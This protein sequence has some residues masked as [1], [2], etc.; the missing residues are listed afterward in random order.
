MAY[1]I[2]VAPED[3]TGCG[4][5]VEICPVK[6]K[7]QEELKALNMALW[8]GCASGSVK[9]TR[10][11]S[12]FPNMTAGWFV[13]RASFETKRFFMGSPFR[14]RGVVIWAAAFV[15]IGS[16]ASALRAEEMLTLAQAVQRALANNPEL[17]VDVSART[18]AQSLVKAARAAYLPRVDFEQ[19]YTGSN[20]PVY[21]FGTLLSQGRFGQANFDLSSLNSPGAL[22]NL[23]TLFRRQRWLSKS[24]RLS[25]NAARRRNSLKPPHRQRQR[26]SRAF[27]SCA[28]DTSL[29][30]Q[31]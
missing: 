23:Q 20:N 11:S 16:L 4:I 19:S 18:A 2:Q 28:T 6:N 10:F 24:A 22:G 15:A 25:W 31:R 29:A 9:T 30:W 26:A 8:L 1:T 5:C 3:C 17:A 7:R 13:G 14:R 12:T 27:A 21:V